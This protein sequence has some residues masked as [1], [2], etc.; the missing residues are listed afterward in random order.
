MKTDK[1][2]TC[3]HTP[4]LRLKRLNLEGGVR[5]R[6][7]VNRGSRRNNS[8]H[9]STDNQVSVQVSWLWEKHWG[10]G[11]MRGAVLWMRGS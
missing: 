10:P 6:R 8:L 7:Y 2:V 11:R 3:M 1:M 5:E 4:F 9:W